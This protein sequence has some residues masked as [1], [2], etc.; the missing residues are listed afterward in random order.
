[1][2]LCTEFTFHFDLAVHSSILSRSET[3]QFVYL[4]KNGENGCTLT[5]EQVE[6]R[7]LGAAEIPMVVFVHVLLYYTNQIYFHYTIYH[8]ARPLDLVFMVSVTSFAFILWFL[9]K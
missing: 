4:F 7:D 6:N 1:M 9:S 5:V 3:V 8:V 2:L